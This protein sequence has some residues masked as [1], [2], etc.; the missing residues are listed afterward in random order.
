[1]VSTC[2]EIPIYTNRIRCPQ[3]PAAAGPATLPALRL[4]GHIQIRF[5]LE[6]ISRTSFSTLTLHV[7]VAGYLDFQS[8]L[9]IPVEGLFF[10]FFS[11]IFSL[12]FVFSMHFGPIRINGLYNRLNIPQQQA[13]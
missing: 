8:L 5:T 10:L 12:S 13:I 11:F 3:L 6:S 9:I 4:V 1:V 2:G 7:V